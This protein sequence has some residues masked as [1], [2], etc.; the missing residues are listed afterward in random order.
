MKHVSLLL[1]AALVFSSVASATQ[2]AQTS[3]TTEG[4]TQQTVQDAKVRAEV[5]K[6]GVG[7]KARVRVK[8]LDGAE[9]MGYINKI[10]EASF[11]VTDKKTAQTTTILYADV[12]KIRGPGLSKGAKIVIGVVVVVVIMAITSAIAVSRNR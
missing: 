1:V 12:Q 7:E 3:Q 4:Q 6:R 5:Q 8:L 9:V 11:E 10:E 2:T